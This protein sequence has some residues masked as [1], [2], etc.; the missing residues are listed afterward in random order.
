MYSKFLQFNIHFH[1]KA[2][3][4]K[5]KEKSASVEEMGNLNLDSNIIKV[6]GK[7]ELV[8][9]GQSNNIKEKL[10]DASQEMKDD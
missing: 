6:K 10:L 4:S 1:L 3:S 5:D 2:G 7:E 9:V 8:G